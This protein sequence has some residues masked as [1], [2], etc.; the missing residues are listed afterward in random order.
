V[1]AVLRIVVPMKLPS[2]AIGSPG[3]VNPSTL[4]GVGYM[5][6]ATFF[7]AGM[8]VMIRHIISLGLHPYE[9]AFF[10]VLFGLIVFLPLF[11]RRG[12]APLQTKRLALHL[13][14]GG[15]TTVSMMCMFLALS[16]SPVAK[17]VAIK[18]SGPLF[19][20]L[21]A[22][23]IMGE[24][25]RARRIVAMVIGFAGTLVIM[26]TSFTEFDLGVTLALVSS[27]FWAMMFVTVKA[28]SKTESSVTTTIYMSLVAAPFLAIAAFPYW[29][30]PTLEQLGWLILLGST[31]SLVHICFAQA[32]KNADVSVISPMDFC[33]LLWVSILAF[34]AFGEIPT[35]T[36][37]I[38]A[39]M[40][41]SSATYIAYRER[42]VKPASQNNEPT[43]SAKLSD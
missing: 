33:K 37:W 20:A 8:N 11:L 16:L 34:V 14:R 22:M 35:T 25:M 41:F 29:Q 3:I 12:F 4:K 2:I 31:G 7:A 9:T 6:V 5:L 42:K 15:L 23:I 28:L 26:G 40:I 17:V 19:A 1:D 18:F 27:I 21:I 32:L 38:G 30:M 24:I 36:T 43:T 10:R 13:F 39:I